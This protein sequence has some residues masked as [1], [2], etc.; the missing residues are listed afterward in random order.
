MEKNRITNS[1]ISAAIVVILAISAVPGIAQRGGSGGGVKTDSRITYHNGPI[2][3]G[4]ATVYM[5]WYGNWTGSYAVPVIEELASSTSGTPYFLINSTYTNMTGDS[6]NGA[7]L[8]AGSVWDNYSRG[9]SLTVNDIQEIIFDK[10]RAGQL[11]L[12]TAGIYVVLGSSDV[13]DIRSDG[14]TFCSP[15]TSPYHGATV[16]DG[17]SVKYGYIGSPDRCP[18]SAAPQFVAPNGSLLPTPNGTFAGDGMASTYLR[19]LNVIVTNPSGYGW[20]DRNGLEN[21]DKCIG[22]FGTTYT[23]PNGARANMVIGGRDYLI[24]A[25]WIN[26]RKGRCTLSIAS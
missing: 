11:P 7:T 24:Q 18:T 12:D 25:N 19:L 6:P 21:S 9:P 17:S 2:M 23:A 3:T 13:T 4:T 22:Q 8:Y 14:S 1:L 20:Y 16:L 10:I 5:I 26:D 15:G